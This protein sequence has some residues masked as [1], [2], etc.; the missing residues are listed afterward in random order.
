MCNIVS[1]F[2][3]QIVSGTGY[4]KIAYWIKNSDLRNKYNNDNFS[5]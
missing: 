4:I 3:L 2:F 5:K 1:V